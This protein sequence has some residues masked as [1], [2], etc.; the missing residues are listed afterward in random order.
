MREAARATAVKD[1]SERFWREVYGSHATTV[2]TFLERRLGNR[3]EAEDLLQETFVR[4]IRAQSFQRDGNVRAYLLRIA[5]NLLINRYRRPRLIE[6]FADA[7]QEAQCSSSGASPEENAIQSGLRQQ[8]D[9]VV[10]GMS[11]E[12]RLAFELGVIEQ[13]AY[14][15][16]AELTG[17][18]LPQ[19]K[20]RIHRARRRVID[21]LGDQLDAV[22][23]ST[24]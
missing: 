2:L 21:A 20:V 16:I 24:S 23:R 7:D 15:E 3:E 22:Q 6:P 12:H 9:Q 11:D 19:V 5:Q 17:W 14:K 10:A 1:S 13:Y 18:S 4:A 8:V